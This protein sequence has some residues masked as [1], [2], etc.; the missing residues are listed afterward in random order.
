MVLRNFS[1]DAS[2]AREQSAEVRYSAKPSLIRRTQLLIHT[3]G[4][5]LIQMAPQDAATRMSGNGV[6]LC[7]EKTSEG[8]VL[9]SCD[10]N[11]R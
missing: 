6:G 9:G 10:V 7:P 11:V 8:D 1:K 2:V 5:A 3:R 4:R